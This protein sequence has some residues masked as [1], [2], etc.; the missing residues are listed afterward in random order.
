MLSEIKVADA[1]RSSSRGTTTCAPQLWPH[2]GKQKA[3]ALS[4]LQS[5]DQVTVLTLARDTVDQ[6]IFPD[7]L[8]TSDA[9]FWFD[10]VFLAESFGGIEIVKADEMGN[11]R[12][13]RHIECRIAGF[14][15]A[16][17]RTD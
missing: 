9:G 6:K 10:L 7:L 8:G 1:L 5:A 4:R 15:S 3:F 14:N 16:I 17:A 2:F 13:R 11:Q 12:R